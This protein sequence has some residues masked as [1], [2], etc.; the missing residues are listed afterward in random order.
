MTNFEHARLAEELHTEFLKRPCRTRSEYLA[1]MSASERIVFDEMTGLKDLS[2]IREIVKHPQ[3]SAEWLN[4]RKARITGSVAATSV[5]LGSKKERMLC[6]ARDMVYKKFKSNPL[7]DWG[8]EN[9]SNG[10]FSYIQDLREIINETYKQ[11]RKEQE[12][13]KQPFKSFKFRGF[14]IPV[15][16]PDALPTV[17]LAPFGLVLDP[18]NH[19]RGIS[20]DGVIVVN[21][22]PIGCLEIKCPWGDYYKK[23]HAIYV[24]IPKYYYPQLQ[25]EL[26]TC[27]LIFPTVTWIDFVVWSPQHFTVDT[28]VFDSPFF[29]GWY[30]KREMRFYFEAFLPILAEKVRKDFV[31]KL[32]TMTSTIETEEYYV[33]EFRKFVREKFKA[34]AG[35]N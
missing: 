28:F 2:E 20:P 19:W 27:N 15:L 32:E 24:N 13:R 7:M 9:E 11:Q 4:A 1:S 26:Y 17:I 30:A 8:V 31:T 10:A 16:D 29:F 21:G 12:S 34:T 23:D 33:K 22:I 18:Y 3:K 25:A 5:G 6:K 14:E 35:D